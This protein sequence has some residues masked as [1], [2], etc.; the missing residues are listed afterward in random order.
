MPW[1][2]NS[3]PDSMKNLDHAVRLKAIEVANALI[4]EG[5]KEDR[6][7]PIGIATA[8]KW[9]E[10]G[11]D[12][13]SEPERDLHV[14]PHPDGWAVRHATSEHTNAVFKTMEEARDWALDRAQTLR[15]NLI[16][17]GIDG[18]FDEVLNEE[19]QTDLRLQRDSMN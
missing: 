13:H 5:Y 14:V 8:K 3:F 15:V 9:A 2:Q 11:L 19:E 17:H 7:I 1:T 16:L 10:G 6:A 18:K 12:Q 4:R